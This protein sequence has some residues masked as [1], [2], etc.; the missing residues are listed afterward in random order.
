MHLRS[1]TST[2]LSHQLLKHCFKHFVFVVFVALPLQIQTLNRLVLY[3][4]TRALSETSLHVVP[5]SLVAP[6]AIQSQSTSLYRI[7]C[8]LFEV[9][10]LLSPYFKQGFSGLFVKVGSVLPQK[11]CLGRKTHHWLHFWQRFQ[12]S[13][14]HGHVKCSGSNCRSLP[15]F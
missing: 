6:A 11:T 9:P 12:V 15:T 5:C 8:K 13:E 1:S 7:H 4:C 10:L 14:K 3:V 2:L